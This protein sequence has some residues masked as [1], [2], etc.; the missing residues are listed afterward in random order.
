MIT[1]DEVYRIG[2]IGKAHGIH[3]EVSF[4][5]DDDI[6]DSVDADFLVLDV[7]G[8]L[9]PFFIEEYRFRSDTTAIIKFE[10]IDSEE[11]A[12]QLTHCDVFF[13]RSL[14]ETEEREL[15]LTMLVGYQ[16]ED[17]NTNKKIGKITGIDDATINVLL[18]VEQTNGTEILI[19]ATD[20]FIQHID[21]K[22][23]TI[24]MT[25][26]EGLIHI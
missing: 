21:T 9:V 7:D 4:Q 10:G 2:R 13:P 11:R 17:T 22:Q 19:P 16:I 3:G 6:F 24:S 15:S 12:R 18:E 25:L 5:F 14:A 8:K 1:T 23:K 20:D 26:P